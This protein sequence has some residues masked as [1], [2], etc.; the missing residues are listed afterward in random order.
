MNSRA[1]EIT[2]YDDKGDLD[3]SQYTNA[4]IAT[5]TPSGIKLSSNKCEISDDKK[6]VIAI[7][8]GGFTMEAGRVCL[9]SY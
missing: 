4:R 5:K 2:L 6:N 9:K 3:L 7:F 8:G 1:F